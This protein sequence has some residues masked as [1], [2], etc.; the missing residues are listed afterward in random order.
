[1]SGDQSGHTAPSKSTTDQCQ[2]C[3]QNEATQ[4]IRTTKLC[5]PCF[6]R[7]IQ[8][9]PI[10]RIEA[11]KASTRGPKPTNPKAPPRPFQQPEPE[12]YLLALSGG[13]SS[14]ALLHILSTHIS[15]QLQ[16]SNRASYR[17]HIVH[18]P[19]SSSSDSLTPPPLQQIQPLFPQHTWT[20]LPLTTALQTWTPP[21]SLLPSSISPASFSALP[22]QEKLTHLLT[23]P[24]SRTA[25]LDLQNLLLD[26]ALLAFAR[27]HAIS[28]VLRGDSATRLAEKVL[29][30][31]A[32]GRGGA[33]S[34]ALSEGFIPANGDRSAENNGQANGGGE[35]QGEGERERERGGKVRVAFPMREV[36]RKDAVSYVRIA[37]VRAGETPLGSLVV[38]GGTEGDGLEK[39][40]KK[41]R[42]MRDLAI[43]EL[44]GEY[45]SDVEGR[46]P[47]IVSNVV[48]TV[49]KLEVR[50]EGGA[51]CGCCGG[52]VGEDDGGWEEGAGTG[53]GSD[54]VEGLCGRC[55]R[56]FA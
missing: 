9:R 43:D 4:N 36:L 40:G 33:L 1:M 50:S 17:L 18:V 31:V 5:D 48:R 44:V 32:K 55:E 12:T 2:R 30:D 41:T 53:A 6:L 15:N 16:K 10:K 27:T 46:Y 3:G 28:T 20:T 8:T 29:G 22:A 25:Q 45:F 47:G 11:L 52:F 37:G 49:G 7:H 14:L 51:R 23:L 56:D 21:P 26:K 42:M 38:G 19:L 34:S 35:G 54:R 39:V 24:R 13:P